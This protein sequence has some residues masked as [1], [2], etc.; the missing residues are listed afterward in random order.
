[1]YMYNFIYDIYKYMRYAHTHTHT[2]TH[3]HN[4]GGKQVAR[5]LKNVS[6]LFLEGNSIRDEG[7]RTVATVCVCLRERE[8]ERER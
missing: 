8:R 7:V 2:H 1:M 6:T 4:R 5:A 3:T